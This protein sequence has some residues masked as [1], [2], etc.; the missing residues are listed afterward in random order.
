MKLEGTAPAMAAIQMDGDPYC[1]QAHDKPVLSN[2]VV[3]GPGGTLA[4]VFVYVKDFKGSV[5]PPDSPVV[6]DQKGCM[7]DPHVMGV[8]VGQK[9][10]V[11]NSDSTLHNVH[12]MAETNKSFNVG[13]PVP[14]TSDKTFSAPEVMVRVKC[15]VHPWMHA[16]VGVLSHPYFAVSSG[17]GEFTIHNLPPG[18]YTIEAWHEKYGA[19]TQQITVGAKETKPLSFTFK[20]S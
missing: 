14:M 10:E 20:A 12:A 18:T 9:F 13:Q 3:T 5:A 15:D 4:N 2:E 7:Y 16:Y 19:Q 17:S 1:Q 8:Q 6:L 11:K